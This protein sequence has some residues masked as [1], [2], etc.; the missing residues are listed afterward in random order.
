VAGFATLSEGPFTNNP[1][2]AATFRLLGPP[3]VQPETIGGTIYD[4]QDLGPSHQTAYC[5]PT[6]CTHASWL[7]S[8]EPCQ[9]F[10]DLNVRYN[11]Y[12]SRDSVWH[13][14]DP[15]NFMNSGVVAFNPRAWP[16]NLDYDPV[17]GVA[18]ISSC[19]DPFVGIS[20][21]GSDAAPG[22]L[23]SSI[24]RGAVFLT[25]AERSVLVDVTGRKVGD[26]LP[27]RND[28]GRLAP[29]IY[30]LRRFAP[31]SQETRKLVLLQ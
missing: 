8:A 25:G 29:G 1:I 3:Y 24:V 11:F 6:L 28:V 12:D 5:D 13:W 9:H 30:F 18:V 2:I 23:L 16:G 22:A 17:S 15:G 4:M 10:L 31:G 14:I 7:F 20:E 27:G 19:T 26:L 21:K